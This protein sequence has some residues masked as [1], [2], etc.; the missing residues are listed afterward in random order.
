M[1]NMSNPPPLP[2]VLR[3]GRF[4]LRS[5]EQR[6][7]A[8]GEL[9]PLGGRA[10]DLLLALAQ[11]AGQLV[12]RNELIEQVWPGR[13]VE[14][15]NLSV[16]VNALRK[17]LGAEWLVTVPGRGYRFVAP[18]QPVPR[19]AAPP[20]EPPR[21]PRTRLPAAQPLLIGRSE[22]LAALGTLIDQHRLVTVVGAGGMGKTRLA[23]ALLQ[24]R[25]NAYAQS[26]CWVELGPVATAE[27]LPAAVA[28]ALELPLPPG[29]ALAQLSQAMRGLQMLVALDNAEHL[30]DDV[31]RLAQA[32]LDAAPGL[33]LVVTSQAPLR[34]S[35]E[36]VL[37]LGPMAVP[38]G[39][40][41]AREAQAFGAVALFCERAAAADHR[42]VLAD[43]DVP[44]VIA[45]CQRL[46]GLALAIE[47]AAA[48]APL[49]GL[50]RLLDALTDRL[51]LLKSSRSRLAP[52]RQQ[53]LRAALEWS[54]GLLTPI[55]QRLFRRL[56]VVA[57]S[58]GLDLV[59][60]L[61]ADAPDGTA[62]DPWAVVDA[63]DELIQRSLVDVQV[64]DGDGT[65][66]YRL[67]ESPRALALERLA[68]AGEE[69]AVRERHARALLDAFERAEW[70]MLAGAQ[71]VAGWR[72]DGEP[73]F[74]DMLQA[75]AWAEKAADHRLSLG[76]ATS[77]LG[78][79]PDPRHV[80]TRDA[81]RICESQLA[82]GEI[83]DDLLA[84]RA[85]SVVSLVTFRGPQRSQEATTRA[86]ARA[87]RLG[88]SD[89]ERFMRY[90]VLCE[91][92]RV[93]AAGQD[94]EQAQALLEE[95]DALA[96]PAWAPVRLRNAQRARAFLALAQKQPELALHHMRQTLAL[97][98]AAGDPS[99]ATRLN[100]A[101]FE[102][103]AG[104]AAA[105]VETGRAL[106]QALAGRRATGLLQ[107]ARL[108]L[109]AA[110]LAL[111]QTGEARELLQAAWDAS[112]SVGR[113]WPHLAQYLDLMALL[114]ALQGRHEAAA[115]WLGA[116]DARY[117]AVSGGRTANEQWAVGR[118]LG[119]LH[120][121]LPAPV[122]DALRAQGRSLSDAELAQLGK[123]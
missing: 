112:R 81:V 3:F 47:L 49:L 117:E 66:R 33:R 90:D 6:L 55:Q 60:Q 116:A 16:Q 97:S 87:R 75:L 101:D 19:A 73:L 13:V 100:I 1:S 91:A 8:D 10:F 7:L 35:S 86:L 99:L 118:T 84:C 77:L 98:L 50:A 25:A 71:D 45:L 21:G 23:Q 34:L 96:D 108:N 82:S 85:W 106:V 110:H 52:A 61:G 11:R 88:A 24:L 58:A 29:D 15:N 27:A 48:R 2:A 94:F 103:T 65:P 107:L 56:G 72:R 40:L 51:A 115:Q 20:P 111:E 37:R 105:A 36:R 120:D 4:E 62:S 102:L 42:F 46:D 70:T 119:L 18:A 64:A 74:V 122:R 14:E 30:L 104:Q 22:D 44:A 93:R 54:V 28:A 95:A 68:E 92:A 9:V 17:A 78:R 39:V 114:C 38:Q 123:S 32:L 59:Q 109:A 76:L 5:L 113:D 67:L 89:D 53:S 83:A 43:A 41:P 31:A 79:V 121:A 57:G 63:L 12:T 69:Q 80:E 26:V